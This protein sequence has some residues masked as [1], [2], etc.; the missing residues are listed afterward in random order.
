MNLASNL[1]DAARTHPDRIAVRAG[2]TATT[3]AELDQAAAGVAAL[4][5]ERSLRP[6]DRVGIMLPN[7]A[8]FAP[9]YYGILRAGGVVVPM[10]PL[11]KQREVAHYLGDSAARLVLA[12][13]EV[14]A[15]ARGGAGQ[16]DAEAIIIDPATFADLIASAG[17]MHEVAVAQ[18][19]LPVAV[20]HVEEPGGFLRLATA[21][22]RYHGLLH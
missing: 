6:G 20:T 14:A 12:W 9:V 15:E 8:E 19:T 2:E 4:L 21:P 7:V 16:A 18:E 1:V 3:Y 22:H 5:L 11:L 10:N 13:H 17:G